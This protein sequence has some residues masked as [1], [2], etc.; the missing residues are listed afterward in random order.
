[1]TDNKIIKALECCISDEPCIK[2]G[3]PLH[4]ADMCGAD[5]QILE[6]FALDLINRQKSE[7][8]RLTIRL[9]KAEHQLDDAMKMYNIIKT[10]A[11]KEFAELLCKIWKRYEEEN[12]S[13]VYIPKWVM[14]VYKELVGGINEKT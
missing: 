1:M 11:Y 10:E 6:K 12:I 13:G 2:T 8:E 14:L 5:T 4:N 9:R 7:I 3:C